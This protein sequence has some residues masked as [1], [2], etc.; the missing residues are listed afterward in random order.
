MHV[1]GIYTL[2]TSSKQV[3]TRTC[4]YIHFL[5]HSMYVPGIYILWTSSKQVCTQTC[6]YIH[7]LSL[8]KEFPSWMPFVC[9][10]THFVI[11]IDN[12]MVQEFAH[13]Y[14]HCHAVYKPPKNG[15]GRW[16]AFLWHFHIFVYIHR[17]TLFNH[18]QTMFKRWRTRMYTFFSKCYRKADHLPEPFLGGRMTVC[19]Q[20]GKFLYHSIV[21]T[22]YKV[23]TDAYEWHSW[24]KFFWQRKKMYVNSCLC[25]YL[26]RAC[27]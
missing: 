26:F 19:V 14:I 3:C 6:I 10:C 8:S 21:D 20:M 18:V 24:R 16:S 25:T 17:Y 13:L 11:G 9:V 4:I 22:D 12:A 5:V 7:F 1:P 27:S 2:W 23:C 15:S